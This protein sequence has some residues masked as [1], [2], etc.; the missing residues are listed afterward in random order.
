[1]PK[2]G[3]A[4]CAGEP[5]FRDRS[6]LVPGDD[7]GRA[8]MRDRQGEM[9]GAYTQQ[10][11]AGRRLGGGTVGARGGQAIVGAAGARSPGGGRGRT[12]AETG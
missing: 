3:P 5:A 1:M 4:A 6:V 11:D 9:P 7:R 8:A 12:L 10:A 2:A